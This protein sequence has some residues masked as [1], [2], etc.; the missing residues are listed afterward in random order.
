MKIIQFLIFCLKI[1]FQIFPNLNKEFKKRKRIMID[2]INDQLNKIYLNIIDW[3]NWLNIRK[4]C[5]FEVGYS[6]D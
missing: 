6:N 5:V 4:T 3:F 1:L 2:E